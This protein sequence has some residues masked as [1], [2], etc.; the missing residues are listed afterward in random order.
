VSSIQGRPL[1]FRDETF[2]VKLPGP[3]PLEF[4][5][6][7]G[8][9]G[10][11]SAAVA[12]YSN[13]RYKLDQI[14][15]DIKLHLYHLPGPS[16]WFPRPANLQTHQM[17]IQRELLV[18]NQTLAQETFDFA[19][20]DSRQ[21]QIWRLKLKVL[22][23]T[24]MVLLF[25]P[26]QVIRNPSQEALQVCF[27]NASQILQDYQQLHDLHGLHHGW[28]AVQN[29][30]AAGATLI[31]SFW[32]SEH[33]RQ[34]VN[35][36]EASR[37]LRTCSTL[38]TIGGEWWPSAKIGRKSFDSVADLTIQRLYTRD[39]PAKQPRLSRSVDTSAFDESGLEMTGGYREQIPED[40]Q[41]PSAA[42]LDPMA[43][44]GEPASEDAGFYDDSAWQSVQAA[45]EVAEQHSITFDSEI[46]SFL[47]DFGRSEFSWSF[48]L[49]D[50]D[51]SLMP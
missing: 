34:R 44:G 27:D 20:L 43:S 16:S 14:V 18:W 6:D 5:G 29:I 46:E 39:G 3:L 19:G 13:H 38:L 50:T 2:D 1:G 15:S 42:L 23:H 24:T 21:G 4:A 31:Y 12:Q 49:E 8:F 45:G 22:Y 48:P 41:T 26:S 32:T 33:V 10:Q 40:A 47:A 9:L 51:P 28:R 11:F 7:T 17:R 25:Q 37:S 36:T 35:V 30:F